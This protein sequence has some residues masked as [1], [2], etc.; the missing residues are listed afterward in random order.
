ML[1]VRDQN[2]VSK[3]RCLRKRGMTHS[4]M[5]SALNVTRA[6]ISRRVQ[7]IDSL[8][9]IPTTLVVRQRAERESSFCEDIF[10]RQEY[11]SE[12]IKLLVSILYWCEGAKYPSSSFIGFTNSDTSMMKTFIRLFRRAFPVNESKFRVWLQLHATHNIQNQ[13][14]FWSEL[15]QIPVTQF[16]KPRVTHAR[17]GRYREGY[18]GTCTLK[19]FDYR[20]QLRMMGIY[21]R[22]SYNAK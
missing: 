11:T 19:Y 16:Y 8:H 4:Q 15:L 2:L 7:G 17:G 5:A 21:T 3:A 14:S 20:I 1:G 12:D 10:L 18:Q 6:Q 9:S 22:F 13:I